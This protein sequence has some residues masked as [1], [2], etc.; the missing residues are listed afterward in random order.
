M[1]LF[2]LLFDGLVAAGSVLG[3]F[4]T[5]LII[6]AIAL[7]AIL[8]RGLKVAVRFAAAVFLAG[9]FLATPALADPTTLLH[10]PQALW[11]EI[12]ALL[13]GLIIA[14][15]TLVWKWIDAHSPLK[16]TQAQQIARDA[17]KDLLD[18]GALYGLTQL[19]GAEQKVGS[20]DVGNVAV[21]AA[22]NFVIQQGPGIAKKLGVDVTSDE[23]RA[24]VIRSVTLRV[25]QLTGTEAGN[26]VH[27]S[28]DATLTVP[29]KAMPATIPLPASVS[30]VGSPTDHVDN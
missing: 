16:N 29:K 2:Q 20:I 25:G 28:N 27:Q 14:L 23:G 5:I 4:F 1:R 7:V 13:I 11:D 6:L 21:A 22:A 26:V 15:V 10:I 9:Y 24:S 19:R 12:N 8:F 3:G 17:F 18:K 30:L